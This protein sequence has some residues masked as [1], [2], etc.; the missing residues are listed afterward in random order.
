[1]TGTTK[2]GPA[3]SPMNARIVPQSVSAGA[4]QPRVI[5]MRF[6][7]SAEMVEAIRRVT[8]VD[9]FDEPEIILKPLR[10]PPTAP[11]IG[12]LYERLKAGRAS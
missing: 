6:I 9:P 5:C 4:P 8:G 7:P 10:D 11:K 1:M 3:P 2:A 12:A